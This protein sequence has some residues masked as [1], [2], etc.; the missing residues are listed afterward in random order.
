MKEINKKTTRTKF[1]HGTSL[2]W[3]KTECASEWE[4]RRDKRK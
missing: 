3:P 1:I 4:K 2:Q